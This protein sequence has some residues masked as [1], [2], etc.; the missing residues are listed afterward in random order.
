MRRTISL[1][2]LALLA[3]GNLGFAR[4]VPRCELMAETCSHCQSE[5][6]EAPAKEPQFACCLLKAQKEKED[7]CPLKH[8]D[9][10]PACC[11]PVTEY[12][13]ANDFSFALLEFNAERPA[14][15]LLPTGIPPILALAADQAP[16]DAPP[17]LAEPDPPPVALSVLY[18]CFRL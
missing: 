9:E 4:T 18:G 5:H 16:A 3:A 1:F 15:V 12:V 7:A 6:E 13:K 2:L 11:A 14:L 10:T 8:G 17:P